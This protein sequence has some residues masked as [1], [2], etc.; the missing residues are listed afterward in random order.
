MHPDNDKMMEKN[1]DH[2]LLRKFQFFFF[3]TVAKR[4]VIAN[5]SFKITIGARCAALKSIHYI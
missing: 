5:L 4:D 1:T 2:Y 3:F